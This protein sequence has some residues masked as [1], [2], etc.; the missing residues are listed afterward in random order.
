MSYASHLPQSLSHLILMT[1]HKWVVAPPTD[2]REILC[3]KVLNNLPQGAH[4]LSKGGEFQ[5]TWLDTALGPQT[6]CPMTRG[7]RLKRTVS[8]CSKFSVTSKRTGLW[9]GI[10]LTC[11]LRFE[12]GG[13]T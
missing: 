1:A 10:K 11:E 5:S 9:T 8:V 7:T 12:K 13:G 4:L 3:L 2:C 6:P